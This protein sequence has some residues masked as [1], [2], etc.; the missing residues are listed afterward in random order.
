MKRLE[1]TRAAEVDLRGVWLYTHETYGTQQANQYVGAIRQRIDGLLTGRTASRPAF[2]VRPGLRRTLVGRHVVF[3][4]E[5]D[6]AVTVLR[7]LHQRMDVG[8]V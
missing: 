7:V 1:I 3:F 8:R 6:N 5:D 4:R 2:E